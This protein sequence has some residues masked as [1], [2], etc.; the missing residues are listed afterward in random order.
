MLRAVSSVIGFP[1][2]TPEEK[3]EAEAEAQ[4]EA[5]LLKAIESGAIDRKR[6]GRPPVVGCSERAQKCLNEANGN[7]AQARDA[8]I[9]W[10]M[11]DRNVERKT[12]ANDWAKVMKVLTTK[13]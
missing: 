8:F 10:E 3:A 4:W 7:F 2:P 13:R 11:K 6:P 1:E 5:K 12:A 9:K